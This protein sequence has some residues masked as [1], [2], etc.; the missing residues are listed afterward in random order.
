MRENVKKLIDL[1]KKENWLE[2]LSS[3]FPKRKFPHDDYP[4]IT[5]FGAYF[6]PSIYLEFDDSEQKYIAAVFEDMRKK[7]Q[8]EKIR[9]AE[10][11]LEDF[12]QLKINN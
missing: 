1:I 8:D 10:K 12:L 9:N 2:V 5:C 7:I 4:Q 6:S 11:K 3:S